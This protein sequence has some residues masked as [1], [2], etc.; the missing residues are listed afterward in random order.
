MTSE[1]MSEWSY[2]EPLR[3]ASRDVRASAR[4]LSRDQARYLVDLYYQVQEYRKRAAGQERANQEQAEPDTMVGWTFD[5]FRTVERN[6]KTALGHYALAHP[7]GEWAMGQ[8]GVGPVLSAG[9]L[10]HIDIHRAPKAGNVWSFAGLNPD[11][12]W[13]KGE[14]RPWNA[15]LKVLAWKLGDSFLKFHNREACFYGHLFAKRWAIEKTK[16]ER[17]DFQA[18]AAQSLQAKKFGAGP[19][20]EAYEAG[21][22]PD[23]RIL[24][25]AQRWAVKIFLAHFHHVL[26]ETELGSPPPRPYIMAQDGGL[27]TDYIPPPG[28]PLSR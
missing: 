15:R 13:R 23:G 22:L 28:W 17:G 6:C 7:A 2:L 21:R 24:L 12:V 27:H 5:A 14:K 4:L 26:H 18:L 25:R 8:Y 10:A 20:R 11:A 19:T 9:L 16:N 3:A 1:A